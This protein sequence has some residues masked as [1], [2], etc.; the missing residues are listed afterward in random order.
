MPLGNL[1]S[2]FFANVY[3][4]ELDYFVKHKLK[5]KYYIRYVDDFIIFE[6]DE[7]LLIKYKCEINTFLKTLKLEL[8]PDKSKVRELSRGICFLGFRIFFYHK[9]LKKGNI[10]K[11]KRKLLSFKINLE[12]RI[13]NYNKIYVIFEGWINYSLTA[14]TYNLRLEIS[15]LFEQLFP[16]EILDIEVNRLL[17]IV[18]T[19]VTL[20][21]L[22]ISL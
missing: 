1:T 9:L 2:Q 3:L 8:H 6:N 22:A 10:N 12:K 21:N 20:D 16:N 5:S 17:N 13:I 4:N 19:L 18:G 11:I 7:N 14:N 15:E